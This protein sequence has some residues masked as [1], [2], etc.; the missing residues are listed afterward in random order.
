MSQQYITQTYRSSS[1]SSDPEILQSGVQ[2]VNLSSMP[3][4]RLQYAS[5][6]VPADNN[7]VYET[8]RYLVPM[9]RRVV[10]ESYVLVNNAPQMVSSP[11]YMQKV[12]GYA[13]NSVDDSE[14]I[15]TQR[16]IEVEN[17]GEKTPSV[18]SQSPTSVKSSSKIEETININSSMNF[19]SPVE[20]LP[21]V[22]LPVV[23]VEEEK[24]DTRYFGELL[25]EVYRKNSDIHNY[26]SDNVVKIRGRKHLLDPSI[27]YKVEK[28]ET[29]DLIPKGMSELTKQQI[30]YLL[31]TRSTAD[32]TMRLLL[33]TFSSLREELL[34]LQDD[35][36]RL[37][38]E[39]EGLEKDLSYKADQASQ[40]DRLLDSLRENNRQLQVSLKEST[41]TQNNLESQVMSVRGS[42]SNR[43]YRI[44]ELEGSLR[45]LEQEN[46]LLRQ[47]VTGQG[48]ITGFQQKTEELSKQYNDMLN[49]LR[50]EKDKEIQ[51]LRS[52]L[53]LVKT[54][55]STQ[56]T[57]DRSLELRITEML[58]KLEQRESLI[59]RQEE[60][61]R[62][63]QKEKSDYSSRTIITSRFS[64]QYPILGLLSDDYQATSPVQS[65]KTI[66]IERSGDLRK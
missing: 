15:H 5:N 38:S 34:H 26:I 65:S 47:K 36:K 23:E 54:E 6:G 13:V 14:L 24:L 64:N 43:D 62:R 46:S 39:K 29:E 7:M 45:A 33:A 41:L 31:Q 42:D 21:E 52:Q 48:N 12:Q 37:E 30:R 4:S 50:H 1:V 49:A 58:T 27:D 9:E 63:L 61:I 8:V 40:Y 17:A 35:L 10:P 16:Y 53:I 56:T 11:V 22:K 66:V 2:Y 32:K 20:T 25:A 55:Y 18:F 19:G 59:K 3:M 51:S 60:E 57:G 44:K 28:D